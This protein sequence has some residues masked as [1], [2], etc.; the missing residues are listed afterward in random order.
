[1]NRKFY[2]VFF[3]IILLLPIL[4]LSTQSLALGKFYE[5]HEKGWHWYDDPEEHETESR[6]ASDPTIQMDALRASVKRALDQAVLNPTV[7]NLRSYKI[8]QDQITERATVFSQKWQEMLLQY[9]ELDYSVKHPPNDLA[10]KLESDQ[11]HQQEDVAI[12]QLAKN[13]GIF[14]FYRSTCPYCKAFAP[15]VK[16]FAVTY[17]IQVIAITTD[18]I[19]L[20]E[21][22]NSYVNNGQAQR[23]GVKVEPALF[24]VNPKTQKAYP[25]TYGLISMSELKERVLNIATGFG[26]LTP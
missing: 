7:E 17:G 2:V 6:A 20:P 23:M 18:G 12:A 1:M 4:F 26:R 9:P 16:Q 21:F 19:S 14:F 22:P 8:K 5:S 15:I 3:N 24:A 10:K 13:N 11:R 25:I